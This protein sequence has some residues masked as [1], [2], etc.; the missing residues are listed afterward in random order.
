M[1]TQMH[2]DEDTAANPSYSTVP[3]A[4]VSTEKLAEDSVFEDILL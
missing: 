1:G 3:L 2:A 4:N